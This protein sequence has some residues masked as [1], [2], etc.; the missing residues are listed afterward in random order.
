MTLL[1]NKSKNRLVLQ[2]INITPLMDVLTVLLFF[3]IKIFTVNTM[4]ID[5]PEQ[6]TLPTIGHQAPPQEAITLVITKNQVLID[7]KLLAEISNNAIPLK[8]QSEDRL[9]LPALSSYLTKEKQKRDQVFGYDGKQTDLPAGKLMIQADRDT[10]FSILKL[11]LNS[12]A[13]S[14]YTDF[15]F[16][17]TAK[18]TN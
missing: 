4:N 15:Q 5:V 13:I 9:T 16:L 14:G 11:L 7:Q 8:Y 18:D 2:E 6:L 12:A 1:K 3:L 17:G 10:N